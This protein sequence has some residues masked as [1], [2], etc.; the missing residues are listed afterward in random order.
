[1]NNMK[2]KTGWIKHGT[3]GHGVVLVEWKTKK[4]EKCPYRSRLKKPVIINC[5]ITVALYSYLMHENCD[6]YRE[7]YSLH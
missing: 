4:M 1:M 6:R 5:N 7:I 2:D 3:I